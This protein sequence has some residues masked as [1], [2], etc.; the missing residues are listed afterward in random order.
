MERIRV[1]THQGQRI[2]LVDCTNCNP[3]EVAQIADQ[4]PKTVAQEPLGSVL[5]LADFTDSHLTRQAMERVKIAAV[6]D[7]RHLKRSAWV[8]TGNL[9]S[10]AHDAVQKFSARKIPTFGTREEA[11]DYLVQGG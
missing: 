10:P 11:M 1:I 4:V 6:F 3:E 8:V 7:R 5:L 2:L 9:P